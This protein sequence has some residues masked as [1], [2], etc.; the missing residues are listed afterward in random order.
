MFVD[1]SFE[2]KPKNRLCCNN[3]MSNMLLMLGQK[4]HEAW[5][6]FPTQALQKEGINLL[7]T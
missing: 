7:D 3:L 5:K 6:S 4:E 1:G 2:K